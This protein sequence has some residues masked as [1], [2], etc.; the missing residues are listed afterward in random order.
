MALHTLTHFANGE[1]F[2]DESADLME[3]VKKGRFRFEQLQRCVAPEIGW[4][5]AS[6]DTMGGAEAADPSLRSLT[7]SG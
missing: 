5:G 3:I 4:G 2:S 7:L 1:L 6:T